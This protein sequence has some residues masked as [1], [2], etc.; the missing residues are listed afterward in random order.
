MTKRKEKKLQFFRWNRAKQLFVIAFFHGGF[1]LILKMWHVFQILYF[2]LFVWKLANF[3]QVI[4]LCFHGPS[5]WDPSCCSSGMKISSPFLRELT[6]LFIHNKLC[7]WP[8]WKITM[9]NE[10]PSIRRKK[11]ARLKPMKFWNMSL[12]NKG[13]L[14]WGDMRKI[15][16]LYIKSLLQIYIFRN[17]RNVKERCAKIPS[18]DLIGNWFMRLICNKDF[19]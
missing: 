1:K 18:I 6:L 9:Q 13:F 7:S 11:M 5:L 3:H 19:S 15:E 12:Q 8:A 10:F 17:F 16:W 14:G 4:N 2:S